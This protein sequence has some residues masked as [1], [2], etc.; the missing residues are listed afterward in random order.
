MYDKKWQKINTH[1]LFKEISKNPNLMNRI[2][3]VWLFNECL[4]N[5]TVDKKYITYHFTSI[6][7][8]FKRYNLKLY[9]DIKTQIIFAPYERKA[10]KYNFSLL[11]VAVMD[12][13]GE[14]ET[15]YYFDQLILSMFNKPEV[16]VFMETG[17]Y[18]TTTPTAQLITPKK[19][20]DIS[21]KA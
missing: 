20:F 12:K 3:D 6:E 21:G 5:V 10:N 16:Q 11:I 7:I 8:P 19:Y 2:S 13:N 9:Y 17:Q 18:T 15:A 4:K 14:M 1:R